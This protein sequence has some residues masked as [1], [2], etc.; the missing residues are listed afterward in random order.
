MCQIDCT[1][2]RNIN[3]EMLILQGIN[4]SCLDV[5]TNLYYDETGNIKKFVVRED[6]FNVD[7]D[8]HFVLGGIEG[9]GGIEFSD[10]K[11][12]LNLQKNIKEEI[13]AK[14]VFKGPFDCCLKSDKL[15]RFLDLILE[16]GWHIHF[17]SL[18]ILYWSI[19]DILDSIEDVEMYLQYI[20]ELKAMLYQVVKHDVKKT[21]KLFY[22]Y[23]YP[24]LKTPDDVKNFMQRLQCVSKEYEKYCPEQQQILLKLLQIMLAKGTKQDEAVFIQNEQG[25]L[26]IKEFTEFYKTEIYSFVNSKLIFDNESDIVQSVNKCEYVVDG[27]VLSQYHFVD[28]KADCMIQL[29]DVFVGIMAKYLHAIDININNLNNYITRFNGDQHRRFCKLNYIIKSSM[30]YNQAFIHQITSLELHSALN[31]LLEEYHVF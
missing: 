13:K 31:K 6:S 8:T 21:A 12:R 24:D 9:K 18:N 22:D 20:N 19:V 25:L 27:E 30:D 14:H 16:K 4:S 10:L 28:S 2:I 11:Q 26:L 1:E 17:Q 3:K 7:A 23:N 15:E 29:S 5:S